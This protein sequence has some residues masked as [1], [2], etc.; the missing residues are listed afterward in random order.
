M[1]LVGKT[2]ERVLEPEDVAALD[3]HGKELPDKTVVERLKDWTPV[4]IQ[5]L[6]PDPN[7]R[8]LQRFTRPAS[9]VL[10]PCL[11]A[12]RPDRVLLLVPYPS[13]CAVEV[14]VV[15]IAVPAPPRYVKLSRAEP[16][17]HRPEARTVDGVYIIP[18]PVWEVVVTRA[19][20]AAAGEVTW[21]LCHIMIE[22][23]VRTETCVLDWAQVGRVDGKPYDPAAIAVSPGGSVSA[24]VSGD[25]KPIDP[26]YL[27]AF[28]D[29]V[30]VFKPVPGAKPKPAPAASAAPLPAPPL[31]PR[32]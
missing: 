17:T 22:Q 12:A 14:K 3:I 2:I 5:Y 19:A 10:P 23:R 26:F 28:R 25:G 21:R 30:L 6:L 15:R 9:P 1:N 8:A 18:R 13:M 11:R 4:F 16:V 29:D 31:P 24:L 27:R 20:N 32:K 7:P